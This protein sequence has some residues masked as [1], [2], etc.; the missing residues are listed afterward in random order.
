ME[1][2]KESQSYIKFLA[3]IDIIMKHSDIDHPV[4][5]K[6]IQYIA[7]GDYDFMLDY[8]LIKKY[9]Q[10]Y[11]DFYGDTLIYCFKEGRK[12]FYYYVNPALDFIEAKAMLDLVYSSHFFTLQT[13]KNYQK[14]IKEMFSEHFQSYF[15]KIINTHIIKNENDQVFY[16]EL[17]IIT[18]AISLQKKIRF[19]YQKPQI[20]NHIY[21]KQELAPI[22][23]CFANNEYYLL[24]QGSKDQNTCI[25]YRL[26][27]IK[28][29][30][31]I[32]DSSFSF[33]AYQLQCFQEKFN[34]MTYMYGEGEIEI[35][36]IDFDQSVYS[37]IIDKFGKNIKPYRI[38]ENTYRLQVKHVINST[39]YAWIIGF[40]GKIQISGNQ[41]Q[42]D[43]F[44]SFLENNFI[45]QLRK[46]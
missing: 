35:I 42:I 39:F 29:V 34:H 20:H 41:K 28:D 1:K 40:G 45:N 31:I 19:T 46:N 18:K 6:D 26:D 22:D 7:Y 4:C 43:R 24:C 8:R 21:K 9:V 30:E 10:I 27:Y 11:N 36:E 44:T 15:E 3:T 25:P 14:R 5:V 32:E 33:T 12:D 2:N 13:K 38:D 17:E 37:H 23:T 16:K